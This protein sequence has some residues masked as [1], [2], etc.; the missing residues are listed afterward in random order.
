VDEPAESF[1]R[2]YIG[3]RGFILWDQSDRRLHYHHE[4]LKSFLRFYV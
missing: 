2:R 4:K 1:C 3:G